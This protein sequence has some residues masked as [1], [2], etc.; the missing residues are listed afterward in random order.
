M[1]EALLKQIDQEIENVREVLA[2]DTIHLIGVR[3]VKGEPEPGAPFGPGPRAMLDAVIK[4]GEREGFFPTRY[5]DSVI[6]IAPQEGEPDLGI[7]LHG[8]VVHEGI[9]WNF[10][11]YQ[12]TEYKGCIVGR[13]AT[14]NKGQLCAIFHLLNIFKKL[15][16]PLNYKIALFVGSNEESGKNDVK[17]FKTRYAPP[18]LSLVPDASFPVGYGG[19]G[20]L[21]LALRAK[22]PLHGITITAGQVEAPFKAVAEAFGRTIVTNS[23]PRHLSSPDPN[24]NMITLMAQQLLED[25][26]L[27]PEDR[28][29]LEFFKQMSLDIY[30]AAIGLD[31][32]SET[33]GGARIATR[34]IDMV[35]GCPELYMSI[36]YPIELTYDAIIQAVESAAQAHGLEIVRAERYMEPYLLD[37]NWPVVTRLAQIANEITGNHKE[38]YIVGGGTYAHELPNALAFGM[39]G[40]LPPED[41]PKGRGSAHGLDESVS[42]DRLQRAMRIYARALLALNEMEW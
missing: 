27:A 17:D 5:T 40:S 42:L 7:W 22:K 19:K 4:L 35:D 2:R 23:M 6:S 30:G 12:A 36:R 3:S 13:G 37:K 21:N 32:P 38:P 28:P 18:R 16:I 15:N 26:R 41:F 34:R 9:G 29:V 8:D 24:G 20:G 11:P 14:D 25:P 1:N 39:D 33:M 10:D 31:V